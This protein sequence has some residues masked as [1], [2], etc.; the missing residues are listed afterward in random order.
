MRIRYTIL[1]LLFTLLNYSQS[2][3][4]GDSQTPYIDLHSQKI[5]KC[6]GLWKSGINVTKLTKMVKNHP[7]SPEICNIVICIGTN[8]LY[9]DL[10]IE[11][12]I[13]IICVKFPNAKIYVVQGSWG[14]G[15]LKRTN[16]IKVKKY[17]K[18][19]DSLGVTVI[20]TPIGKREPHRDCSVYKKIGEEIDSLLYL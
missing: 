15:N 8:D 5:E 11:K 7:V 17:Y 2:L 1:F 14:W 19:F 12:L 9:V 16:Y 10:G 20:K 3:I 18:K 13:D 6:I 4:I